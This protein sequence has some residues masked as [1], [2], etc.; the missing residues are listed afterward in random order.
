MVV[1]GQLYLLVLVFQLKFLSLLTTVDPLL[2]ETKVG[3]GTNILSNL[4]IVKINKTIFFLII[5][6]INFSNSALTLR[7][8]NAQVNHN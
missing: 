3:R 4:N 5:F 6:A 2:T 1:A 7:R 8:H